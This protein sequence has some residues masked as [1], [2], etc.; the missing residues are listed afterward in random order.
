MSNYFKELLGRVS[1]RVVRGMR[2]RNREDEEEKLTREEM[3]AVV[4]KLKDEKATEKDGI[5]AEV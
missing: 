4:R 1:W 3:V 2:A 5:T